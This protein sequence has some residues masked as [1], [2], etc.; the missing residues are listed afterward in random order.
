MRRIFSIFFW[1]MLCTGLLQA[2]PATQRMDF[3]KAEIL[4]IDKIDGKEDGKVEMKDSISTALA[5]KAYFVWPDSID[6]YIRNNHFKEVD[7]KIYR[8]YLFRCLRRVLPKTY[9]RSAYFE[10]LFHHLYREVVALHDGNLYGVLKVNPVMSIHTCGIYRYEPVADSFLCFASRI[11]PDAIFKYV[12]DF[13]DRLYAQHVVDY[14]AI[15]AP[16]VAKKYFLQGDPVLNILKNSKD[17]AV[18]TILR[19]NDT[20]GKKSNAFI[21]LDAIVTGKMT[22]KEADQIGSNPKSYFEALNN[23]RRKRK[24]LAVYSLEK[25]LEIQALKIVRNMNDLHNEKEPIRFAGINDFTT[26]QLYTLVVYSEEDIFTSTFDG[27]YRRFMT[28]LG[29]QNGLSLILS[30]GDN[31]FRTFIKQFA[32]YGKLDT[33]LAGNMSV[34]QRNI[35]M[36]K[37]AAGLDQDEADISQ[38]VEVADA[39]TSISDMTIKR[40]LQQTISLELTRVSKANNKRG[41]VIYSLLLNLFVNNQLF[42]S[43]WYKTVSEVYKLP[44]LDVLPIGKLFE[45]NKPSCVWQMYFYDDED[46]DV[47]FNDLMSVFSDSSWIIEDHDSL[48]VTIKSNGGKLVDIY[49]NRP[50]AEYEGQALLENK[51]DS[52]GITPDV[53]IHRGHSY[54]AYKT[55]EKTKPGTKIFVLGSCGGYHNLNDIIDRAPNVSIISSKQIGIHRINNPI[56]RE[57][58]DN[59]REG[60]DV[61]WQDLWVKIDSRLKGEIPE[62][63]GKFPD[64]IPPHKNLGAI[65]IRAYNNF[66]SL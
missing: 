65:F 20:Y 14:T 39:Y 57:L 62:I 51:F 26:D 24:P 32:A 59:I 38:A 50:K 10:E 64:Y 47:S 58:A 30:M 37:F 27:I 18:K 28:K 45:Q 12:E 53:L 19:I 52:L 63:Y 3:I 55:I 35:L 13:S 66:M 16:H 22:M 33:F 9:R 31:R 25:E 43:E 40:I 21:L 29:K 1:L 2:Q 6:S 8:D 56:L 54:Y 36:I 49:A 17:T 41:Q 11:D 4:R 23:I 44:P 15:Y 48:Y 46:G 7:Q 60:R 61:R 42:A 5:H 34:E